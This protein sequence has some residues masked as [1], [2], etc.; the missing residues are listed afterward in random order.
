MLQDYGMH[1]SVFLIGKSIL[2]ATATYDPVRTDHSSFA[3]I[4]ATQDVFEYNSH[5]YDLHRKQKDANGKKFGAAGMDITKLKADIPLMK[6]QGIDTPYIAYPYGVNTEA[7]RQVLQDNGYRMAFT[8]KAGPVKP[9]DSL[10]QLNR[11]TVTSKT[12][13]SELLK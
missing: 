5:T 3:E 4:E 7:M 12:K 1:A 9:G 13:L 2:P 11:Y 10:M 8:V 6:K